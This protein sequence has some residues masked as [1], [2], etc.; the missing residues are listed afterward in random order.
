[1][2]EVSAA[3]GDGVPG[4]VDRGRT[5][6]VGDVLDV[7][8]GAGLDRRHRLDDVAPVTTAGSDPV[9]QR[10]AVDQ[11]GDQILT[12]IEFVSIVYGQDVRM[13]E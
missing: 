4:L 10:A 6:V 3:P 9:A 8:R 12:S 13:I 11:F 5:G 7:L 2:L 1:M